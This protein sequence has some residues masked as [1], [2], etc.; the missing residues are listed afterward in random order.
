MNTRE[1]IIIY[2]YS[3]RLKTELLIGFKLLTSIAGLEGEALRGAE[4]IMAVYFEALLADVR[5]AQNI[6]KSTHFAKAES[7]ITEALELLKLYEFGDMNR[8]IS[9]A[10]SAITTSCQ[11]SMQ[12]LEE[13]NLL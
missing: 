8:C 11:I 13:A 12:A 2:Q 10:V 9:E 1:T 5:T 3:E 7:K 6:K 4:R